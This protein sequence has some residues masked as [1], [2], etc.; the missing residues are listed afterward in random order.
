MMLSYLMR[1]L[2]IMP[3][4][5]SNLMWQHQISI[6]ILKILR[7]KDC[8]GIQ[9]NQDDKGLLGVQFLNITN[10]NANFF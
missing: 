8:K 3:L 10:T 5:G 4:R 9:S 2:S 7:L 6:I 1:I